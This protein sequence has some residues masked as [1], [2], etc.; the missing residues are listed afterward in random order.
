MREPVF[1]GRPLSLRDLEDVAV[2]GRAVAVD[3]SAAAKVNA[4]RAAVEAIAQAGDA[5][6]NVY[7]VNTGFGA[8]RRNLVRSHSTGIGPDLPIASVRGMML[9]RAQ[10]LALGHSGVRLE[11]LEQLVG[12]LNAGVHPRIP[13]QGS[14][15]ASGDL[16]PLAHLALT[17]IGEGESSVDRPSGAGTF[18][19]RARSLRA[20][21]ET[22]AEA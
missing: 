15:G 16:A 5:A 8:L 14:V 4:S 18:D 10:V 22:L 2:R 19:D 17:M 6:P 11:V 9:L 7:V 3:P 20:S 1:V 12:L 21:K 13:S